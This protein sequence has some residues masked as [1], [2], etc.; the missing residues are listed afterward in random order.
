MSGT[1]TGFGAIVHMLLS[2]V[3]KQ[4]S[5]YLVPVLNKTVFLY[6]KTLHLRRLKNEGKEGMGLGIINGA[7]VYSLQGS[8]NLIFSDLILFVILLQRWHLII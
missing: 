5:N 3:S 1:K 8:R 2:N 7:H 4:N 6:S